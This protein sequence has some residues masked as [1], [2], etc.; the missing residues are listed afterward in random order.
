MLCRCTHALPHRIVAAAALS[1]AAPL[2]CP[3]MQ[4]DGRCW[5]KL[6]QGA[7]CGSLI[8]KDSPTESAE[9]LCRNNAVRYIFRTCC[10]CSSLLLLAEAARRLLPGS[11][12]DATATAALPFLLRATCASSVLLP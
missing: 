10:Y 8:P 9:S 6:V 4:A 7:R 11:R 5:S 2:R 1:D 3:Q 12:A